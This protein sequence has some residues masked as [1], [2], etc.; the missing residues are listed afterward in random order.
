MV[1]DEA[2]LSASLKREAEA[3][4]QRIE[5]HFRGQ[6]GPSG[7]LEEAMRYSLL[8]GGKRLRPILCLWTCDAAMRG[9]GSGDAPER[10]EAVWK[11]ALALE[12]LHT[13][14]LIHDD[15]PAMDDDDLR[16]G[17]PSCHRRFDEATA[18]LAGDALQ[19]EAFDL[20]S[21]IDDPRLSRECTRRLARASGR[22]GMVAGQ[23][24][25]IDTTGGALDLTL[26]YEQIFKLI[27]RLKTGALIGVSMAL[28]AACAGLEPSEVDRVEE[29]GRL[30]GE[31]F[32]IV[33][34]LLDETSS[35]EELGKS[36]GKDRE[37]GKLTAP[38]VLGREKSRGRAHALQEEA[39]AILEPVLSHS[40][41][42][43]GL[44]RR[45]ID[46]ER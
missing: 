42:L 45:L 36:A 22:W 18:I 19:T 44:C 12:M 1:M 43:E 8:A 27:H 40:E 14:S 9:R 31:V 20:L 24:W 15:L 41:E 6:P 17:Q 39:M 13:Y 28:G 3:F 11:A 23:Q 38:R 21:Q 16:R 35:T 37:Q 46:R 5:A 29:G 10:N 33:D 7:R 32:Q 25:D 30:L 2:T 4:E 26:S 34:D